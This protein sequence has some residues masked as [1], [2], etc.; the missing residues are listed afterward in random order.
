[1]ETTITGHLGDSLAG[2]LI[3]ETEMVHAMK[4]MSPARLVYS[5]N[6]GSVSSE[7]GLHSTMSVTWASFLQVV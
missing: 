2:I 5:K 3:P 7:I 1:M 6:G 4:G